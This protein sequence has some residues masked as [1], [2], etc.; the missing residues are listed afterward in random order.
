MP[1]SA[2]LGPLA[3]VLERAGRPEPADRST[4]AELGRALVGAAEKLPRPTP[5][6]LL[7]DQ[8]VRGRPEPD[9]PP[10][11]PDRWHHPARPTDER[12][13]WSF[14]P[15]GP[16]APTA[17]T[18]RRRPT[19]RGRPA[20]DAPVDRGA[21]VAR[22]GRGRRAAIERVDEATGGP[23]WPH[24]RRSSLPRPASPAR[25]GRDRP[26]A[27]APT[28]VAT[29]LYDGDIDRTKDELAALAR[30]ADVVDGG[31]DG[32]P[33]TR[34]R[35]GRGRRTPRSRPSRAPGRWIAAGRLVRAARDHGRRPPPAALAAVARRASSSSARSA[36]AGLPRLLAVPDAR[37][38]RCPSSS[39]STRRRRGPRP[40]TST[41]TSR[42]SRTAATSTP[43][44]ARSSAPRRRPASE[45][46]E[47]EP[48]LVVVSE[49]PE[50]RTLPDLAGLPLAEAETDAGRAAARRPAGDGAV[51]R[52][53]AGRLRDLVVGAVGQPRSAPAARCCRTPRWPSSCR[54]A[55]RR[56]PSRRSSGCPSPTP[57]PSCAAIQ[58]GATV[59][60]PV[61]SDTV[62]AGNVVVGDARP[63]AP[64]CARGSTVTLVPS[65]GVDL[66]VMPD[67]T[68]QTL[69][70]ARATLAAA[71]LNVGSLL[72]TTQ[73]IFHV[74]DRGSASRP[75]PATSS[76]G[77]P[78]S[79]WSSS[80]RRPASCGSAATCCVG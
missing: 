74:G 44:S 28:V 77:A 63:P 2:D 67:L 19:D 73:G 31:A 1:V 20:T 47:G 18:A 58:L 52:G 17:P 43:R 57:P 75:T 7:V 65:K 79:T 23:R 22:G 53:R 5:I 66:V 51:R 32:R 36:G 50:L 26:G 46:G 34:L 56:G 40:P 9:A 30:P 42:S 35:H 29:A 37:P 41:G 72:G 80:E 48:F 70:Q 60:E 3:S 24:G 62:P 71:G 49:G 39:V 11:R 68:G 33:A 78:P 4:A 38:T 25:R 54:P 15:S 8:P 45:L 69:D 61:F 64:R 55:R 76:S 21:A 59:G 13:S 27:T 12:R 16:T 10:Q 14:P 6:P